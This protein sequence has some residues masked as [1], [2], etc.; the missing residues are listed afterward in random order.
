MTENQ[1]EVNLDQNSLQQGLFNSTPL[2]QKCDSAGG[3]SS[4]ISHQT[5]SSVNKSQHMD[6]ESEVVENPNLQ[7]VLDIS[8]LR[9]KKRPRLMIK[10]ERREDTDE[11]DDNDSSVDDQLISSSSDDEG[12]ADSVLHFPGML[13]KDE[14]TPSELRIRDNLKLITAK[15]LHATWKDLDILN[16][17]MD[18][19]LR[20]RLED[21]AMSLRTFFPAT[22]Q[23]MK[24]LKGR[25]PSA[26]RDA[27]FYRLQCDLNIMY[28][29]VMWC[30]NQ[31]QNENY[32]DGYNGLLSVV[33]PLIYHLLSSCQKERLT[34][35]Y[36]QGVV[37]AL[38]E[39]ETEPM[40]RPRQLQRVKKLAAQ[41]KH[42]S[43]ISDSF[44]FRGSRRRGNF[45]RPR[46][47]SF[48][49]R[50]DKRRFTGTRSR[51]PPR[52]QQQQHQQRYQQKQQ[53][54]RNQ[55]KEY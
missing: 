45:P 42:I 3:G 25:T 48:G 35:R 30:A 43:S 37:N 28:R 41:Q 20:K 46:G 33:V 55:R 52:P 32:E 6:P 24:P 36:P 38:Y 15:Y 51:F 23:F 13:Q 17:M 22:R 31:F 54:N 44:F 29:Y 53:Q 12:L 1:E 34:V 49:S 9:K 19:K 7:R 2:K 47:S 50:T 14:M 10:D 26:F 18:T 8:P 27:A 4:S 16:E 39:E 40:L 21:G 11:N 5:K